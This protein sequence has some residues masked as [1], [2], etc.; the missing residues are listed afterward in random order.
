MRLPDAGLSQPGRWKLTDEGLRR[1]NQA[2]GTAY[3]I[4]AIPAERLTGLLEDLDRMA[5]ALTD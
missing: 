2:P 4:E 1:L 5:R 3:A